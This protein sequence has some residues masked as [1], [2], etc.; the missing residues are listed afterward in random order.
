[1]P[2]AAARLIAP[3]ALALTL[4]VAPA[5]AAATP[6]GTNLLNNPGAESGSAGSGTG[7]PPPSWAV[8][9]DLTQILRGTAGYPS[10][11]SPGPPN[12]GLAFFGGGNVKTSTATQTI[13]VA[14]LVA[15]VDAATIGYD[16]AGWLGGYSTQDDN[17]KAVATFLGASGAAL[18]ASQIGPVTAADRGNVTGMLQ[19]TSSGMLPPG[20]RSVKVVLTAARTGGAANDGYAD[21][22]S[23]ALRSTGGGGGGA[24]LVLDGDAEAATCTSSGY[25][26][27]TN[28]GWTVTSGAPNAVCVNNTGGFPGSSAPGVQ[29]GNAYFTGGARGDGSMTQ[30]VSVASIASTD[31]RR[32][33]DVRPV[34]VARRLWLAE[35]PRRA[36]REL[37]Q[38]Q[39]GRPRH[40]P[41][42]PGHRNRPRQRDVAAAARCKRCDPGRHALDQARSELHLRG[43]L[44]H[45]RLR[46]AIALTTTP[47]TTAATLA[48]PAST[49]PAFDHVFVVMM[50]NEN[51]SSTSNTVDGGT[52]IVGNPQAPYLNQLASADALLTNYA[53]ITHNSDPNYFAIAAGDTFGHSAGSGAATS[54]CI[55]TCTFNAPSLGDR[56]EAVGKSWNQYTDGATGDCD[57]GSHG[58]YLPDEAPF[59]Y[60]P[61]MKSDA[62]YCRAHWK[63][64]TTLA[65]DLASA[66]TTPSFAWLA[67][68]DCEDME[69][70]GVT[71]GDTWLSRTLPTV[72]N[73]PA[74]T[75]QRSLLILA[76][77]EDG[78]NYPGGFGLGQ[79]NQVVTIV[80]GS[81]GLVQST[82]GSPVRYDHYGAAR[83]I[84]QALGLTPMT[85]NDRYAVPFNDFFRWLL[86]GSIAVQPSPSRSESRPVAALRPRV[87]AQASGRLVILALCRRSVASTDRHSDV[88][89]GSRSAAF[90]AVYSGDEAVVAIES[91][92]VIR[93]SL[94]ERALR[95]V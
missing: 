65:T 94:P 8:G 61:R 42:R 12:R 82:Y 52:G 32:R 5:G 27:S 23:L 86:S 6:L 57:T 69:S 75:T 10:Q 76:F 64:L 13:A 90:H 72:F 7:N 45:R 79:T 1:M 40:E 44:D 21:S 3:F 47:A 53:A 14:D 41:A 54:N 83:T 9:G 68:D 93:G 71:A 70:C 43:G 18:G 29:P 19:R 34:G 17:A 33:R 16:L 25:D 63:P 77:D 48:P 74:W 28:P 36:G 89:L 84:E 11:S 37:P 60:F 46:D 78:N 73:S 26:A 95:L 30:T 62:T 85:N 35:R 56:L 66:F 15:Q 50:E 92:E 22:L 38:R 4:L 24:N 51:Y 31:R 2:A 39:R 49:V 58:Y 67:A 87:R 20:T 91:G 81:P 59:Y 88:L 55:T 80:A